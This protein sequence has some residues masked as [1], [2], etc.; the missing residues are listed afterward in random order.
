MR[1][2]AAGLALMSAA[3]LQAAPV[4]PA[5]GSPP[6]S[7]LAGLVVPDPVARV[8]VAY[9]QRGALERAHP[10]G[11]QTTAAAVR[12]A[13]RRRAAVL[14][15][16]TGAALVSGRVIS[17]RL[18]ALSAPGLSAQALAERLS[19]H[20]DVE[21]VV[22]DRRRRAL[23]VPNDPLFA[24]G[25][26]L[27][28]R[29]LTGGPVAGQWYLRAPDALFRSATDVQAAWD[30]SRGRADLTV[31]VIDTG[32]LLDHEDLRG[33]LLPGYDF[34]EDATYANDGDG[35]DSDASDPGD[36]ISSSE[37]ASGPLRGCGVGDSSWHG[38]RV[39]SI[40]GA[41]TDNGIGMAGIAPGVRLLPVR[42]LGKCGGWDSDIIAG[43]YWAAG[44]EQPGRPLNPNPAT[45]LNMS[46]GGDGACLASYQEAV[47]E[48][49]ARGAVIVA[50]AGN[51]TGRTV[52]TPANCP[53]VLAVAG[54][55]HLGTKVGFSDLGPEIA[56]AAPGGNCV[57]IEEGEPCLYPI[58]TAGNRGRR[59]PL[60]DGFNYA[61]SFD[62]S[63]G[64]SF[65]APMVA[66]TVALM[67]S[68]N[69]NLAPGDIRR[70]LQVT[71][72]PFPDSGAD[73][74]SDPEPVR[75]CQPPR[76]GVD[77]LQ[78]YCTT[79]LCGAGMLDAAAAVQAAARGSASLAQALADGSD[80]PTDA[81]G[82][83]A[84]ADVMAGAGGGA[85]PL[86]WSMGL[87]LAAAV[88][89]KAT[90]A[91]GQGPKPAEPAPSRSVLLSAS[92]GRFGRGRRW[93]RRDG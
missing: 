87:A 65:S 46:L 67:L 77:Q 29:A 12:E 20:P 76:D 35:R 30:W 9:R 62:Y 44:I 37:D 27:D 61:D 49:T 13:G 54:L 21:Y 53:G 15:Q 25:P 70:L 34:L 7:G 60:A 14:A 26:P 73:N 38:T 8:I 40:I 64:T 71:A 39:A 11:R 55:R 1:S 80:L 50:A 86:A 75:T 72:R 85:M 22:P 4:A 81:A 16:S 68:V 41:A 57:N 51:S 3:F 23:A 79:Q 43:M 88:L 69:P 28:L 5:S 58:V 82:P 91:S 47:R 31:A 56:I 32:V 90:A 92:G 33:R 42:V 74:G 10:W 17:R 18:H 66:G 83:G 48:I 45:V 36:W 89:A 78:C 2:L 24:A 19:R 6:A 59:R 63:V 84:P 93:R 52:G